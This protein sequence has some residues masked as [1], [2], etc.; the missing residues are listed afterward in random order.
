[1]ATKSSETSTRTIA[2]IAH[3]ADDLMLEAERP[4]LFWLNRHANRVVLH[5]GVLTPG[6]VILDETLAGLAD[7]R[8]RI[9]AFDQTGMVHPS[10]SN[11]SLRT[12]LSPH[13]GISHA[14]EVMLNHLS[15]RDALP[16]GLDILHVSEGV[17]PTHPD[18]PAIGAL[19]ATH[20][21]L[22][23]PPRVN[24]STAPQWFLLAIAGDET[25][26]DMINDAL[27]ARAK[28]HRPALPAET[29][30]ASEWIP[31]L[32]STCW[33]FRV[34]VQIGPVCRSRWL[35]FYVNAGQWMCAQRLNISP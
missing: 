33:S 20:T 6:I 10:L 22:E 2:A 15:T 1:M 8:L 9:T 14:A 24:L 35:V 25:T 21:Y 16:L 27:A 28:S 31:T 19:L 3:L 12:F 11:R 13:P 18:D 5:P 30:A 26:S 34:D 7:Q 17:Y 4:I 29:T 23:N 32:T